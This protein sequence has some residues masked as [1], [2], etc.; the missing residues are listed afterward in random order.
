[1]KYRAVIWL[2][3]KQAIPT[4]VFSILQCFVSQVLL[5]QLFLRKDIHSLSLVVLCVEFVIIWRVSLLQSCCCCCKAECVFLLLL[6]II[7]IIITTII[8]SLSCWIACF[9]WEDFDL[10]FSGILLPEFGSRCFRI[11]EDLS[12]VWDK[13]GCGG[14]RIRVCCLGV[15]LRC[16]CWAQWM[17][18]NVHYARCLQALKSQGFREIRDWG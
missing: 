2:T 17:R 3:S 11:S 1:M 6:L 8:M 7:T 9:W 4:R 13:C 14:L 5:E 18:L 16:L 10:V 12:F 15:C